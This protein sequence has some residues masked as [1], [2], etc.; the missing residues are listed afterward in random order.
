MPQSILSRP[1]A[2]V[3]VAHPDDETLW[4]GGYI[5]THPEFDWRIVTLCRRGDP[6]RGPK[7]HRVL[8]HY[9]ANG[10]MADLDDGPIQSP[11]PLTE[12]QQTIVRLLAG[13]RF[14]LMLTHGPNGE[15]TQHL[16]H[17]ECCLAVT[18]LWRA[19]AIDTKRLL[20]FAYEDGGRAYLPRVRDD[21]DLR[22]VLPDAVWLEKRRL[23]TDLYG[24]G[25]DSWEA[26]STPRE[27]GFWAFNSA[28]A[29][30]EA[31]AGGTQ[32]ESAGADRVPAIGG[33]TAQLRV[34]CS[35]GACGRSG[36]MFIP[37][38]SNRRR[39][40]NGTI[41]GFSRMWWLAW[42]SGATSHTWSCT[43]SNSV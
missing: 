4:C 37:C 6:D 14:D 33:R 28:Q 1:R 13:A 3:V 7:F 36:S 43:R 35:A 2:A 23:I 20:L 11:L 18:E 8:E 15:Y 10:D 21:A 39:K 30:A 9:R 29:A 40:R 22:H 26:Q 34:F 25:A 41:A 38:I 12:V 42:D 27:E 5:L 19:G 31:P 32:H 16:R 17:A 24:F